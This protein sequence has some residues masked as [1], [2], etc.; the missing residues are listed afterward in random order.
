MLTP[1]RAVMSAAI[2]GLLITIVVT[3]AAR[4]IPTWNFGHPA[5]ALASHR[6]V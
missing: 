5:D 4:T 6:K 2:L 1:T 3:M